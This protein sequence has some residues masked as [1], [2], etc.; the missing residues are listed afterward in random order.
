MKSERVNTASAT[1]TAETVRSVL[2]QIIDPC[3]AAAGVPAGLCE[4]GLV[5]QLEI[6]NTPHG[7]I[8][9]VSIGVTEPLCFMALPFREEARQRLSE[10]DGVKQVEVT[11]DHSMDWTESDMAPSYRQRVTVHRSQQRQLIRLKGSVNAQLGREK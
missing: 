5:R 3:S 6:L 2:D 4:M 8:I 9:R 1:L 11:I 7:A 10:L